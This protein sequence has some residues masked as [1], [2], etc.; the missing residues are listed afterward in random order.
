ML[1]GPRTNVEKNIPNEND[2]S[3]NI[4]EH[5]QSLSYS[6]CREILLNFLMM[7]RRGLAVKRPQ[8]WGKHWIEEKIA[9]MRGAGMKARAPLCSPS[10]PIMTQFTFLG[11]SLSSRKCKRG[12]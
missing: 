2:K 10:W 1:P 9:K 3:E 4:I 7:G 5:K 6:K 12:Q 8:M 11:L